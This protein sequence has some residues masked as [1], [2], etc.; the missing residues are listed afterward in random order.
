MAKLRAG[1]GLERGRFDPCAPGGPKQLENEIPLI[2]TGFVPPEKGEN[3][4]KGG[5]KKICND[6]QDGGEGRATEPLNY[7]EAP[8]PRPVIL[9]AQ[10]IHRK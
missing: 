10:I 6:P 5:N 3:K 2:R 4:E 1:L 8:S 7:S 9:R